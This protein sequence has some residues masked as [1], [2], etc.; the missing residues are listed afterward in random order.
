MSQH[1]RRTKHTTH[2]PKIR[3][4]LKRQLPLPCIECGNPVTDADVWH[5]AHRVAAAQGGTTTRANT[6]VAHARCN[7]KSGGR[8]GA[9]TV[10]IRKATGLGRRK[11]V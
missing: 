11:W 9:A 5:V 4:E 1:H 7:L 2:A 6:G 10:N 3:A 8:L